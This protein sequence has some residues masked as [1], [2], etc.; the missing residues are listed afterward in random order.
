MHAAGRGPALQTGTGVLNTRV[1]HWHVAHERPRTTVDLPDTGTMASG[2]AG[3][4]DGTCLQYILNARPVQAMPSGTGIGS[5]EILEAQINAEEAAP[6]DK[7]KLACWRVRRTW[8]SMRRSTVAAISKGLLPAGKAD[9]LPDP[10]EWVRFL[11]RDHDAT[12]RPEIVHRA[13]LGKEREVLED[14]S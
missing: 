10:G 9:E 2:D 12:R 8:Y 1:A 4:L 7:Q 14:G 5:A 13:P 3:R 6:R 11:M